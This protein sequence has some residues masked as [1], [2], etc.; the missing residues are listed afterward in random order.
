M[1][2]G[3]RWHASEQYQHNLFELPKKKMHT[4]MHAFLGFLEAHAVRI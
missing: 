4:C 1:Q 3:L 2:G